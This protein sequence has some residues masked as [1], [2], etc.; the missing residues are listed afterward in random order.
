MRTHNVNSS[1][2]ENHKFFATRLFLKNAFSKLF[3]NGESKFNDLDRITQ[4]KL[5]DRCF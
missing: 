2:S 5:M 4:N 1:K 3:F